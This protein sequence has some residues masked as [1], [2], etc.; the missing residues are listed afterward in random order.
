MIRSRFV[1]G[2]IVSCA[3]FALGCTR[4]AGSPRAIASATASPVPAVSVAPA[5]AREERPLRLVS[6]GSLEVRGT[7]LSLASLGMTVRTAG[8]VVEATVEHVFHNDADQTLEGTFRFPLPEGAILTGLAME[9]D[10]K[11]IDGELVE[12]DKARKVYEKIVDEMQ[13]PALLEWENGQTFKLR[14]FPIEAKRDKRVVMRFVAPL[15]RREAGPDAGLYFGFRAPSDDL[16]VSADRIQLTV[17]G[18]RIPAPPGRDVFVRTGD[19]PASRDA[20]VRETTKEGSYWLASVRPDLGP[21]AEGRRGPSG[22]QALILLCD[23][24][25]SML[26]ARGLQKDTVGMLLADLAPP[27]RFTVV[28]GDV[29]TR[30]LGALRPVDAGSRKAALELLDGTEP[31]GASDLAK[32]LAAAAPAVDQARTEGLEPVIVYLG[33]GSAT[34]G[35]TR[36]AELERIARE[37]SHGAALHVVM[38]GKSPD[39]AGAR[40]L[41]AGGHGRLLRPKTSPEAERAAA[42]IVA[43]R[44]HRRLDDVHLVGGDG[45]DLPG[46]IPST[47]YEGDEVPLLLR[48]SGSP[49]EAAPREIALAGTLGERAFVQKIALGSATPAGHVAQRWAK[50][51]I[52]ALEGEGDA[53]KQEIVQTSLAHGVMSRY[54]S[55]LVLDSEEAYARFQI[56]RRAKKDAHAS[57]GAVSGADL[58]GESRGATVTP[59]HLQPGDPEVR[60]PAPADAESVVVVFPF[61]ETK[62]ATYEPASDDG[63]GHGGAWVVRF[64]VDRRTPD[65][66]YEIVARITHKDGHVEIVR[67]PYV[68][69]TQRPNLDVRLTPKAGGYLIEAKQRLSDAEVEAQAPLFGGGAGANIPERRQRYAQVLTDAKRVEVR[70]PDGQTLSL[71]HVRLGEFRGTWTPSGSFGAALGSKLRVVAVDRALNESVT[72]VEVT[73]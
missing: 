36:A 48:A 66:S 35:E 55:F 43:T 62:T 59:D 51:K 45:F 28:T 10:G 33:D 38:L 13:D 34:W 19:L 4:C 8:D 40:A 11:L 58:D 29:R 64:L 20:V 2:I 52:E 41:A 18:R 7:K 23:R 12:R 54:T 25:R 17:D 44:T 63:A 5:Y 1:M 27:D 67:I 32:L 47:L 49:S 14:V 46:V 31:D 30:S 72:E 3:S 65:G 21:A 6:V 69:D 9:I 16:T 39:E 37:S 50:A 42:E 15:Q 60:I 56:E 68:V 61:G 26:E 57:E 24:S 22:G 73:R 70:T 71:V 53:H